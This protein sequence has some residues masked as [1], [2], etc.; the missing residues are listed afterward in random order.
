MLDTKRAEELDVIELAEDLPQY[1]LKRGD[2][3]VVIEVFDDPE[4]YDLEFVDESGTSSKF[5]YSVK[6]ESLINIS[7]KAKEVFERGIALLLEGKR[8]EAAKFFKEAFQLIPSYIGILNNSFL[9]NFGMEDT[10]ENIKLMILS[11]QFLLQLDPEYKPARTNLAIAYM[12]YGTIHAIKGNVNFA[13]Q[14]YGN[15]VG[16][17]P[18]SDITSCVKTNLAATYTQAGI[19]AYKNNEFEQAL[20][21]MLRVCTF[22]PNETTRKNL[23]FAYAYLGLYHLENRNF[24]KAIE[25]FELAEYTGLLMPELLNDRAIAFAKLNMLDE[26]IW[27]FE[28]ALNLDPNNYVIQGN[29]N[30]AQMTV[31]AT[32]TQKITDIA[33]RFD[34]QKINVSFHPIPLKMPVL[35]QASL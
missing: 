10:E 30:L 5:G 20:I 17:E 7:A 24:E 11:F 32:P 4:A 28:R 13:E 2:R 23:S 15:A 29:L 35:Q 26:A 22:E 16:I 27:T 12:K 3:G 34:T 19:E 33:E 31:A 14:L 25:C 9:A 8:I 6:P 1:S 21:Y 18:S